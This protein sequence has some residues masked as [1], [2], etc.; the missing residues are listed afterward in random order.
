M[1][2][3]VDKI[4]CFLFRHVDITKEI[5]GKKVLYLRRWFIYGNDKPGRT[6]GRLCLHKICRSDDDRDPHTH[7]WGFWTLIVKGGYIDEQWHI[8]M[9]QTI[10]GMNKMVRHGPVYEHLTPGKLAYRRP[11]HLHRVRLYVSDA[12][13]LVPKPSWNLVWMK[14]P[15]RS[16]GFVTAD[17]EWIRSDKYTGVIEEIVD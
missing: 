8:K 16:W 4:L 15:E 11:E 1:A 7:P 12:F 5:D 13:G 17:G 3:I 6:K 14:A 9:R 2:A 10:P